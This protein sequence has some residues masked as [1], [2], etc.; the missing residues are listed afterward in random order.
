MEI[1]RPLGRLAAE[2][3]PPDVV[4]EERVSRQQERVR[5]EERRAARRVTR[6]PEGDDGQ[7]LE[8][9]DPHG[10]AVRRVLDGQGA[11][12]EVAQARV[13]AHAGIAGERGPAR[14]VVGLEVRVEDR[15]EPE[16]LALEEPPVDVEAPVRVHHDGVLAVRHHVRQAPAPESQDLPEPD[17]SAIG[18]GTDRRA[19]A[20]GRHAAGEVGGGEPA[21]LEDLRDVGGR[22][23]LRADDDQ[24]ARRAPSQSVTRRTDASSRS[25]NSK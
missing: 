17:R 1:L 15:P 23:A 9:A 25:T 5:D 4:D 2:I 11:T 22:A 19:E 3:R 24:V 6:G 8:P 12:P 10:L 16:P 7:D 21:A 13:V 20:P 18:D 14:D